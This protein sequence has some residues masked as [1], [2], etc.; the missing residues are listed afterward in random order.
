MHALRA[1]ITAELT[2]LIRAG[3]RSVAVAVLSRGQPSRPEVSPAVV[4]N[5]GLVDGD[6]IRAGPAAKP[7]RGQANP[8]LSGLLVPLVRPVVVAHPGKVGLARA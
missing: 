8:G 7:I 6:P 4:Q 2:I 5:P 1:I 3:P